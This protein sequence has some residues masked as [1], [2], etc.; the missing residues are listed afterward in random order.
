MVNNQIVISIL[1]SWSLLAS[2]IN[3]GLK[4]LLIWQKVMTNSSQ[5]K[6]AK[7]LF[8]TCRRKQ[9]IK[10]LFLGLGIIL[11][12]THSLRTS[13]WLGITE[14]NTRTSTSW[15]CTIKLPTVCSWH[16][17]HQHGQLTYLSS[18]CAHVCYMHGSIYQGCRV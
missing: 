13:S 12:F 10:C 7:W 11:I 17:L 15:E 9:V 1:L 5:A 3:Q 4:Q 2:D 14:C 18:A 8:L 6:I 16:I